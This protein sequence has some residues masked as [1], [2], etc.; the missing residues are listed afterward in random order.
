M[1]VAAEV[2]EHLLGA[3][4]GT[5]AIDHPLVARGVAQPLRDRDAADVGGE[6]PRGDSVLEGGEQLGAEHRGEDGDRE[7]EV[8]SGGDPAL[9]TVVPTATRTDAA[10]GGRI[11]QS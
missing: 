9:A 1:S 5:F 7:K 3:G 6:L 11:E 8:L 10:Q 4:E 2:G